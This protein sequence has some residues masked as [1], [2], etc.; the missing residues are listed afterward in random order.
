MM[1]Q[2]RTFP[3]LQQVEVL[4]EP[5]P[6]L[7]GLDDGVDVA[8]DGGGQ[9]VAELLHVLIF[10]LGRALACVTSMIRDLSALYSIVY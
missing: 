1:H 2:S 5:P 6:G 7:P 9:R 4:A 8:A 3:Y 10:L